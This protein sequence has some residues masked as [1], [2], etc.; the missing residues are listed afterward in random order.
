[1]N[2]ALSTKQSRRVLL[3]TYYF[4]PDL[5]AGSFRAE[6]LANALIAAD[7]TLQLDV[8][9]TEPN[10]YERHRP[11]SSVVD[12]GYNVT[13]VSLPTKRHGILGQIRSFWAF[14][15]GVHRHLAIK[16]YDL[17]IATS[18]RLMTACLG[19]W[20]ASR[21]DACLYL[22][23]RD[24]F[25]ETL[26]DLFPGKLMWPVR[27][28]FSLLERWPMSRADRVNVVSEGF[29]PYFR[30]RY[31]DKDYALFTNGIDEQFVAKNRSLPSFLPYELTGQ[32]PHI[33]YA[34][35]IGDGQGLEKI[36][37]GLA[38][39]LGEQ[40]RMTIVGDGGAR[41]RLL[42]ACAEQSVSLNIRDPMPREDL[43]AL[44]DSADVLFLHLN[45]YVAFKRV[46]P[47]KLFEYAAT[48]KPILAGVAGYARSFIESELT[49]VAVFSPCNVDEAIDAFQKLLLKMTDRSAFIEKYNRHTIMTCMAKDVI[50]Y[51]PN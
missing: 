7:P 22:D 10:R 35:N 38:L 49:G 3:L 24:I 27:R 15:L 4:P 12:R 44:Y 47:S 19:A 23:V 21:T 39:A 46:L 43:M 8:L 20:A 40:A 2:S 50:S 16:R 45:D 18:S 17:V 6:A 48:G 42:H 34:G 30:S 9:T 11:A 33:V 31:T 25:A 51:M 41:A 1:M 29:L 37:P 5:S 32:R 28:C 13:S 36:L 14:A 26:D